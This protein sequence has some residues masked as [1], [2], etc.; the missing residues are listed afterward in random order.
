MNKNSIQALKEMDTLYN[1]ACIKYID[2]KCRD[3]TL[4]D[5]SQ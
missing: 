1:T 4:E 3:V 2:D 5:T